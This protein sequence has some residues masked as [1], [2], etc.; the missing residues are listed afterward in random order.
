MLERNHEFS[1]L[2]N[3]YGLIVEQGC[4]FTFDFS[5]LFIGIT[6]DIAAD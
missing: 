5:C 3:D 1:I 4:W 6:F 2:P